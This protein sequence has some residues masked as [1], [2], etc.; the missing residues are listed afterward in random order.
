MED[1][2]AYH[3][4]QGRRPPGFAFGGLETHPEGIHLGSLCQARMRASG[5]SVLK[6]RV[7]ASLIRGSV[8]RVKDHD[9]TWREMARRRARRGQMLLTYLNRHEGLPV[10]RVIKLSETSKGDLLSMSDARFRK[11]APE[12][13]DSWLVLDPGLLEI[14]GT[15][16]RTAS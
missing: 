7:R 3:G 12:A 8:P 13:E 10:E 1:F 4:L 9:W 16:R 14:L 11:I 2:I 15:V 5:G 6:V